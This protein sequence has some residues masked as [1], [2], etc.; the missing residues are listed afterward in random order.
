MKKRLFALALSLA[1]CLGLLTPALAAGTDVA[2][3]FPAVNSYPGYSDIQESENLWYAPY[4]R[5]CYEVG[6]MEGSN[7][8]FRHA[9]TVTVAQA[10][11]L[12]VRIDHILSG[13]DGVVDSPEGEP[14]YAGTIDYLDRLAD[15][16]GNTRARELLTTPNEPISRG[17][18]FDLMSMVVPEEL[19][20]P[21]NSISALPDTDDG[22]VLEFYNAGIL[23]GV[24]GYG[25]F[26]ARKNLSR[27]ELA[28]MAARIVRPELR[29]PFTPQ[30]VEDP[31]DPAFDSC[32]YLLGVPGTSVYFTAN[33][34]TVTA[35]TFLNNAVDVANQLYAACEEQ[36]VEFAWSNTMSGSTFTS[37]VYNNGNYDSLEE[38]WTQLEDPADFAEKAGV[39]KAAHILVE[40]KA[41]A[42]D[43][44]AQLQADPGRFDALQDEYSQD[45][46]DENGALA[47]RSYVFV[48]GQMVE[49]FESG[50]KA[51]QPGEIGAPVESQFG[52]HIIRRLPLTAE[53]AWTGFLNLAQIE[54]ASDFSD[55]MD[56]ETVYAGWRRLVYGE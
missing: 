12:A 45:G 37:L 19:L 33:G 42:D 25:T 43:L 28:A 24:N 55:G 32:L 38:A 2:A 49:E 31:F 36:G 44:Y 27:G 53:D 20:T 56:L 50:T 40:D 22:A 8:A 46:R 35:E 23:T 34:L 41:Q 7:G 52:W 3:L 26:V 5:L 16:N 4:A 47:S 10:A 17:D 39:L 9:D 11:A 6:L 13:G 51:L 1:L 18:F 48:P 21:I 30:P 29:T 14:W 15:N 54:L